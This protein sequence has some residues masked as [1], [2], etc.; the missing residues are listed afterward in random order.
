MEIE[1]RSHDSE[2][3]TRRRFR[4]QYDLAVEK[5]GLEKARLSVPGTR[6]AGGILGHRPE[7]EW[8]IGS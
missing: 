7:V 5:G 3:A 4:D 2:G 6:G 8:L 1:V